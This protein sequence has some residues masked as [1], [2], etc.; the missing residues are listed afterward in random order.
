MDNKQ[1]FTSGQPGQPTA[2]PGQPLTAAF[3]QPITS[4]RGADM[5][6]PMQPVQPA[7]PMPEAQ[8]NPITGVPMIMQAAAAIPEPKKDYK[9]LIR[10]I[11]IIALSLISVTFIGLFIWMYTQYDDARTNVDG[12]INAAVTKAIDENTMKLENEFAEREKYPFQTFAGP[13]D[14]GGLTFEYPK[15]WSVYVAADAS[16]GGDFGA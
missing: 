5:S 13:E 7:Q 8:K 9:P 14:Y 4:P 2:Q 12:Q 6:Q 11:V 1:S 16:H 15:T 3:S 10:T